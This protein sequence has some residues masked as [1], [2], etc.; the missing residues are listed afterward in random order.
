MVHS[1][2]YDLSITNIGGGE[3]PE[4]VFRPAFRAH[5]DAWSLVREEVL[6]EDMRQPTLFP[7]NTYGPLG[8]ARYESGEDPRF[9]IR[10]E[11]LA[12]V[13]ALARTIQE[14]IWC[15]S[16]AMHRSGAESNRV[17]LADLNLVCDPTKDTWGYATGGFLH[18]A[19]LK[20]FGMY[21]ERKDDNGSLTAEIVASMR[22]AWTATAPAHEKEFVGYCGF[23][24]EDDGCFQFRCFGDSCDMSLYPDQLGSF[25][26]IGEQV[27]LSFSCHNV[28]RPW[29]QITFIAGFATLLEVVRK[30]VDES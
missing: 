4:L 29:Q 30:H 3:V 23:N 14:T 12:D 1:R 25:E 26:K 8:C 13:H 19:M 15:L 11:P 21:I 7:L 17:A 28:D 18:E 24:I 22:A 20:W 2:P 16:A 6:G 27:F 9:V 5:A 10:L